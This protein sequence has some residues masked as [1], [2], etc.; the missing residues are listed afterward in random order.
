MLIR[1]AVP[2]DAPAIWQIIAPAIRAGETL[3]LDR[4][5]SASAGLAYWL[6]PEKS[7]FVVQ[8]DDG[9]LLGSYYLCANHRGGGRHVAN[10]GYITAAHATGRGVARAMC[11]H[12]L[13]EARARG[14]RAMQFNI[15]IST[16]T[17]A[18]ALWQAMGFAV[19]GRLPKAFEHPTLGFVDALVMFRTLNEPP[20][21]GADDPGPV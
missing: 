8:A 9:T 20:V 16:N 18:V 11:A 4:D 7:V 2:A 13:I 1:A 15:V 6:A 19:V 21:A 17:R 14:Y 12:S 5:M 3:A 10:A